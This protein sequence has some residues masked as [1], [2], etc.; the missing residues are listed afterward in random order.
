MNKSLTIAQFTLV[1]IGTFFLFTSV[2]K[3]GNYKQGIKDVLEIKYI[4][5]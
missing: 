2:A 5:R 3:Y 1:L 4:G